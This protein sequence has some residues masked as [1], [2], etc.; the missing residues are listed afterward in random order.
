MRGTGFTLAALAQAAGEYG[1]VSARA[2]FESLQNAG[3]GAIRYGSDHML[4]IGVGA[5]L[6]WLL[7]RFFFGK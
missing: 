5:V 2:V 4:A 1:G 3:E 7:W 6:A